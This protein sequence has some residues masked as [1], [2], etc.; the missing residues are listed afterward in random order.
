MIEVQGEREIPLF[1]QIAGDRHYVAGAGIAVGTGGA[2]KDQG[3]AQ[4]S[5]RFNND[6]H[7]FEVMDIESRHGITLSLSF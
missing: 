7:G 2:G 3:G 5:R 1:C 4:L 6:L